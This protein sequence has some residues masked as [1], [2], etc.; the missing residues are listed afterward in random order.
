MASCPM[1]NRQLK[2]LNM[3][4]VYRVACCYEGVSSVPYQE[5]LRSEVKVK[6]KKLLSSSAKLTKADAA[7]FRFWGRYPQIYFAHNLTQR[8]IDNELVPI[9]ASI[10]STTNIQA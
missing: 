7:R 4:A 10:E 1:V 2:S 6:V 8:S 5:R 3:V 9:I